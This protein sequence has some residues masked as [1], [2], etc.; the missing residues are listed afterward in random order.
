[1]FGRLLVFVLCLRRT[2]CLASSSSPSPHRSPNSDNNNNNNGDTDPIRIASLNKNGGNVKY[3]DLVPEDAAV[4]KDERTILSRIQQ[5]PGSVATALRRQLMPAIRT[6]FLP[7]GFPDKTPP[8]YLRFSVWSWVQDTSTQLRSVLATQKILEGVGVGKEGATALSAL[9]NYLVRDGCGMFANLL[10]TYAASS[11]FRKDV[12]RWRIF[13]DL[14]VDIGIT[15]EVAA[16]MFPKSFFL[17]CICLGNMFKALCGVAAGATGG[18]INLHWAKGSDISDINAKFGAQHTVTGAIG[19]VF[20]GLFAKSVSNV[21]PKRLWGMYFVLT[22]LHL[23]AN[24]R[25]MRLIS[26]DYLNT[27]RLDMILR[28]FVVPKDGS[29]AE[30]GIPTPR[31]VAKQEPLWFQIPVIGRLLPPRKKTLPVHF[32]V[33]YDEFCKRSGKPIELLRSEITSIK[34]KTSRKDSRS[35]NEH[36]TNTASDGYIISIGNSDLSSSGDTGTISKPCVVVSFLVDVSPEQQV[37]AY[38]HAWLLVGKLQ[39]RLQ[40]KSGFS[41]PMNLA[42]Q[43]EIEAE[44]K[45]SLESA[46]GAFVTS[47]TDAGWDLSGSELQTLGYEVKVV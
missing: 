8:G 46:W 1:M 23:Y 39:E 10:F 2:V 34:S 15:L 3:F 27:V 43:I 7:I 47:C 20:A 21:S 28:N 9:F 22:Y 32:G 12:K 41:A 14:S 13:A 11:G 33:A 5:Q 4:G 16:T 42:T 19:L 29:S 37:K 35:R 31:D 25:C 24:I 44:A 26:F 36:V 18:S 17:P 40:T 6:T 30:D 38:L 45:S